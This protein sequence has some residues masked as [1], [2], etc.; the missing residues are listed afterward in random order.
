MLAQVALG[1][2]ASFTRLF[3]TFSDKVYSFAYHFSKSDADAKDAVQDIFLRIFLRR[4]S[5]ANI[6]DFDAYLF[7]C[8]RNRFL[9]MFKQ[10]ARI[11]LKEDFTETDNTIYETPLD[12]LETKEMTASLHAAMDKLPSKQKQTY[13]LRKEEGQSTRETA[14]NMGISE[15]T[16]KEHLGKALKTLRKI[17]LDYNS[18]S[19]I[20]LFGSF[21]PLL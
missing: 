5:L 19:I 9:N 20:L 2:K 11:V 14:E 4:E 17:H 8:A 16:V 12:A 3:D 13:I 7:R 15:V 21:L 18:P 1:D 6:Q 10:S